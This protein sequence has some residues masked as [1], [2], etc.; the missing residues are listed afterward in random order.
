MSAERLASSV[1]ISLDKGVVIDGQRFPFYVAEEGP[2]IE[3]GGFDT[4]TVVNLPVLVDGFVMLDTGRGRRVIDGAI[5]SG[6]GDV[7][8]WARAYVRKAFAEAFPW[9]DAVS[10]D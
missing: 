6:L 9:L 3:S 10:H 4:L 1:V 2:E 7:G 5:G 8:E